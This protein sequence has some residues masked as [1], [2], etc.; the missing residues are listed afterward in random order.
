MKTEKEQETTEDADFRKLKEMQEQVKKMTRRNHVAMERSRRTAY[1]GNVR[2]SK[3][4]T[5]SSLPDV[6]AIISCRVVSYRIKGN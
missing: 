2:S 5:V 6:L 3:P 4:L 1:S